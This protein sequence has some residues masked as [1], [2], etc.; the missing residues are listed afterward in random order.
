MDLK[1]IPIPQGTTRALL[2]WGEAEEGQ[3]DPGR[4]KVTAD[5]RRRGMKGEMP[6]QRSQGQ[7]KKSYRK[8]VPKILQNSILA[9]LGSKLAY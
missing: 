5:R 7:C 8:H 4:R 3:A 1:V 6:R 9:L 2:V